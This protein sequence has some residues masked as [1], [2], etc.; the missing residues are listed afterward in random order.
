MTDDMFTC[1]N[2]FKVF[3]TA[4]EVQEHECSQDR[5]KIPDVYAEVAELRKKN[6]KLEMALGAACA[7]IGREYCPTVDDVGMCDEVFR[8]CEECC[9]TSGSKSV[10]CWRKYFEWKVQP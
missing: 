4:M 9:D 2:C 1:A 10:D 3:T 5:W 7:Y 8:H 6:I